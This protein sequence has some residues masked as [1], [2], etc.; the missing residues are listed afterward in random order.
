MF[1]DDSLMVMRVIQERVKLQRTRGINTVGDVN[2]NQPMVIRCYNCKGEGHIAKQCTTK[3]RVKDNELLKEKMLLAQAQEASVILHEEQRY[4]LADR[5]YNCK[6]KGH[7]AKQCT[8]K[9]RVKDNELLKEKMLLAQAQE[10]SVILHKEQRDFL[11]DRLEEMD[12]CDDLQLHTTSN[13]KAD[14]VKAYDS[15]CDNKVTASVIFMASLSPAGSINGDTFGPAYD[16]DILS[17]VPHYDT[18]HETNVLNLNVQETEYSEH[19]VSNN[20]SFNEP[21][22]DNNV[23]SYADYMV[24]IKNNA[25]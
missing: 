15:Y 11:A 10:A 21:T 23:I 5:C 16:F 25:S 20:D 8:T 9:K 14:H 17:E 18:Y 6:G 2:E 3:K 19:L 13:F 4:F 1:K 7:I 22:S 24:T 12:D